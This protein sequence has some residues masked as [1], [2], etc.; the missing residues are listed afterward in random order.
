MKKRVLS[1]LLVFALMV[2]C[3]PAQAFAADAP[4]SASQQ[5]STD[6]LTTESGAHPDLCL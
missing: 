2:S 3:L 5:T 6:T 4:S 1:A